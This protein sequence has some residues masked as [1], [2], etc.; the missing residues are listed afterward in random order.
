MRAREIYL[1]V[2]IFMKETKHLYP[3]LLSHDLR[4]STFRDSDAMGEVANRIQIQIQVHDIPLPKLN[5]L[6]IN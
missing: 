4:L 6:N 1:Y 3:S 2:G 5:C